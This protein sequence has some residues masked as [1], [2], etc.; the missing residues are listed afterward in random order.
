M[1]FRV[2][3][4]RLPTLDEHDATVAIINESASRRLFPNGA[5]GRPLTI[6][7]RTLDVVGV[8]ADIRHGGPTAPA[9]GTSIRRGQPTG[10]SCIT[11]ANG[12]IRGS[13]P[14]AAGAVEVR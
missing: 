6:M 10:A 7:G 11:S 1:G 8:V 3:Q 14:G 12:R 5:I 13:D 4:G 9:S 2:L